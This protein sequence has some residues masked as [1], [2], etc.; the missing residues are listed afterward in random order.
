MNLEMIVKICPNRKDFA[1]SLN[2]FDGLHRNRC[3]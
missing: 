3:P 2:Y 1:E